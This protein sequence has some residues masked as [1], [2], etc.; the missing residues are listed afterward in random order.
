MLKA[1]DKLHVSDSG[2][3]QQAF[4]N[5]AKVDAERELE[6]AN[7]W[8]VFKGETIAEAAAEFNR[9]N[10]VQ[11]KIEN[12]AIA[13]RRLDYFR[14]QVS[15]P[16]SF[17]TMLVTQYGIALKTDPSSKVLHLHAQLE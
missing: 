12:P 1:G 10:V 13:Q 14:F 11:I 8:L 9:R 2:L 4:A 5:V 16:E 17:A 15:S 7:G 6:W 3:S